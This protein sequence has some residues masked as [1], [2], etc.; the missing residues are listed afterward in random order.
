M[1]LLVRE[2]NTYLPFDTYHNTNEEPE[3]HGKV[4]SS[5]DLTHW[6]ISGSQPKSWDGLHLYMCVY[7]CVCFSAWC[8]TCNL[9]QQKRSIGVYGGK[10]TSG[11]GS[12]SQGPFLWQSDHMTGLNFGY[13]CHIYVFFPFTSFIPFYTQKLFKLFIQQQKAA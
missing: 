10:V 8:L 5:F 3:W 7:V 12:I 4:C 2:F 1:V 9:C 11:G 6:H 13:I